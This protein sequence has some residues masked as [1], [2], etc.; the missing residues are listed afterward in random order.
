MKSGAPLV[1]LLAGVVL[2]VVGISGNAGLLL[3]S[4]FDPNSV[5]LAGE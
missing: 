1:F 4:I 3:A 5:L 2:L